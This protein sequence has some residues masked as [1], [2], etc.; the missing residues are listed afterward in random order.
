MSETGATNV[1][2]IGT[3]TYQ[4]AIDIARSTE[5][6]LDQNV[7]AYLE[8]A[9]QDIWNRINSEPDTYVMSKDEFAVFNFYADRF[10]GDEIA[11]RAIDRHWR[12]TQQPGGTHR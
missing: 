7:K 1:D 9:L 11:R 8:V 2:G 12:H 3:L 6:E 5:G 4:R 10:N